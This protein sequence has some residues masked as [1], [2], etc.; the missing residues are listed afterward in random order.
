MTAYLLTVAVLIPASGWLADRFG[1]RGRLHAGDRLF[2][3][4][5]IG[6]AA[7]PSWGC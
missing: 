4:A 2:T 6:C 1:A 3:L 7:A 5:S